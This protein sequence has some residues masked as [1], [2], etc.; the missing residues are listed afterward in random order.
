MRRPSLGEVRIVTDLGEGDQV[1]S[2]YE[3]SRTL[4]CLS[5]AWELFHKSGVVELWTPS[6]Q[7]AEI[8][9]TDE[10]CPNCPIQITRSATRQK[11]V[12][13]SRTHTIP[14]EHM[15]CAANLLTH[16]AGTMLSLSAT[17]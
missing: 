3:L 15:G 17:S 1:V 10:S 7:I 11:V 16:A 2:V 5:L 13:T 14:P 6:V 12:A 8:K 4:E 9:K